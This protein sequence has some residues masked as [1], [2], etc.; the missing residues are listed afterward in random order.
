MKISF[1]GDIMLGRFVQEKYRASK[2]DLVSSDVIQ[3]VE[4]SDCVIANLESPITLEESPNASTFAGDSSLLDGLKWIDLFS[5]SNNHINDF[6]DKGINDT[7]INLDKLGFKQNGIYGDTYQ[8][9]EIETNDGKVAIVTC[10]DLLNRPFGENSIFKVLH[11]NSQEL[12][13]V[14]QSYT[15]K[16]YFVIVFAHC[17]SLFSRIPSPNT[18]NLIHSYIDNGCKAIVTSHSHCLGGCEFYNNVPIFWNIGDFLMDGGSYRRRRACV[19]SL[20]I[21]DNVIQQWD[22]VPTITNQD[23]QVILPQAR[24]RELIMKSF[25]N[26]SRMMKKTRKSYDIFYKIQYRIEMISHSLSTLSFLYNTKGFWGFLKMIKKR[27]YEMIMIL[28]RM[29]LGKQKKFNPNSKHLL[30]NEDIR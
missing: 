13:D 19:L 11:A 21:C 29:I 6:G 27:N 12:I 22:I 24:D 30:K 1:I 25:S 2:Y 16:D 7:I 28:Y 20:T 3:Q 9:F 15:A 8:P 14:I 26:A 23:L 4:M 18:R 10:T 5:L 17:G